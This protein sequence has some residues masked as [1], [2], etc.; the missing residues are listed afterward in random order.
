MDRLS[1]EDILSGV[2]F[3]IESG[4]ADP[5][6]LAVLGHSHGAHLVNLMLIRTDRFKFALSK[7]GGVDEKVTAA[8]DQVKTPVLLVSAGKWKG[9]EQCEELAKALNGRGVAAEH[10]NY[11]NDEH[12]LVRPE[13]QRDLLTR[14]IDWMDAYLPPE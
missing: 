6:R 14:V 2:D 5:D 4:L 12:V 9:V 3:V 8:A 7:E 11:G 1:V 13:N 10:V